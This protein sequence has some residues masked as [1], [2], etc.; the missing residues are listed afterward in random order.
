LHTWREDGAAECQDRRRLQLSTHYYV[1]V[2]SPRKM[3]PFEPPL[4]VARVRIVLRWIHCLPFVDPSKKGVY[5]MIKIRRVRN[6]NFSSSVQACG[7]GSRLTWYKITNL[8]VAST[9]HFII[10]PSLVS[11]SL[12]SRCDRKTARFQDLVQLCAVRSN[13]DPCFAITDLR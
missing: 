12:L 3:S 1:R 2:L 11:L 9:K 8:S 6:G 5:D 4:R 7:F 13:S 10:V